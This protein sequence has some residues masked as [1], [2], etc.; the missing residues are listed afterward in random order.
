M[1]DIANF[2]PKRILIL[3]QR[4]L[5]DVIVSTPVFSLLRKKFPHA[6][7]ALFTEDKC[8]PLVQHDPHIDSFEIVRKQGTQGFFE[9]WNLYFGI[10]QKKY[11]LVVAMQQLP[12]CQLATL[13]SFAK[14]RL[15]FYPRHAYR[16]LLYNVYSN[17]IGST[18][19]VG[20]TRPQILAPLGIE[21]SFE[22]PC[23]YLKDE[24]KEKGLEILSSIGITANSMF[25]TLDA[26]HKHERNRWAHYKELVK[27]ILATYPE[28]FVFVLRAP[29]EERQLKEIIEIDSKRVIMPKKAP[30][31][32]ESMAC[33]S[34]AFLHIGNTSA[35]AHMAT[36][37]NVPCLVVL[38]RTSAEWHCPPKNQYKGRAKQLEVRLEEGILENYFQEIALKKIEADPHAALNL[39]SPAMVM[40]KVHELLKNPYY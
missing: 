8:L 26:T 40:E 35:P 2:T 39:I 20:D 5:G 19:Y 27:E 32:R 14:V 17:E 28:M 3:Q 37:L 11:D 10:L 25:M 22:K 21:S 18:D 23:L 12:R 24:E 13:F 38:A 7:I 9:Q 29:G 34:Y 6:H 15:S 30:T 1:K 33:M 16:K 31:I 4:Q 36:A